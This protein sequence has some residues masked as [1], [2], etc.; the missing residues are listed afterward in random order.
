MVNESIRTLA[1]Q[2]DA[3]V[4]CSNTSFSDSFTVANCHFAILL[5]RRI[6][7]EETATNFNKEAIKKTIECAAKCKGLRNKK[8]YDIN[9]TDL[10]KWIN[11]NKDKCDE[12]SEKN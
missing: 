7:K 1:I 9:I 12:P 3:H 10:K 8:D 4:Y 6:I 11:K 5:C 2:A